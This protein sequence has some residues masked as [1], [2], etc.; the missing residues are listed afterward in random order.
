MKPTSKQ[1]AM[2]EKL[3]TKGAPINSD[4]NGNPD[5]SMFD[6]KQAASDYIKKYMVL[7]APAHVHQPEQYGC[8][9]C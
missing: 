4:E 8:P 9:N 1:I 6:C 3:Q 2:I 5:L 7:R